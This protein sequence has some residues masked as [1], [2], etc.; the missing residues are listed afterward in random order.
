MNPTA[1]VLPSVPLL[2]PCEEAHHDPQSGEVLVRNPWAT[3]ALPPGS[4]FPFD[5]EELW[6]YARFTDGVGTFRLSV[7]M[8]QRYDDG[9]ER[10]GGR[11]DIMTVTFLGGTQLGVFDRAFRMRMVPF[12]E[13]GLYEFRVLAD[14]E[15]LAGH[16]PTLRVLNLGE[17]P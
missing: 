15:E 14:D 1:R 5:V 9:S 2:F 10:A 16:T 8:R 17:P 4:S 3:V 13:P 11:S 6:V 12:D 7:E